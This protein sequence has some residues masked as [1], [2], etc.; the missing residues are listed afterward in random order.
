[1]VVTPGGRDTMNMVLFRTGT[2]PGKMMNTQ[3]RTC[4]IGFTIQQ[5]T[6]L[7]LSSE[8]S[9]NLPILDCLNQLIPVLGGQ[10]K[11][12]MCGHFKTGHIAA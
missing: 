2:G 9:E 7:Q 8:R 6:V 5:R 11:P 10:P 12:A 1:M 4:G 3:A